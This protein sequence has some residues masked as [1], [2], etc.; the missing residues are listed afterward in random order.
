MNLQEAAGLAG[1]FLLFA[2]RL[3]VGTLQFVRQP[4]QGPEPLDIDAVRIVSF[5][6][7][8]WGVALLVS[9]VL[10]SRLRADGHGWWIWTSLAGLL[11]GCLG[12]VYCRRRP[13]S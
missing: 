10:S 2:P 11:L 1:G 3:T 5:G 13:N 7:A 4:Q 9:L 6:T 8:V 12:I